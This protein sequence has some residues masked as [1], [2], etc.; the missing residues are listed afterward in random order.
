VIHASPD[1]P[2]V[3]VGTVASGVVTPVGD[4]TNLAFEEDSPAAGTALPVGNLPIG[5][6]ATGT[7]DPV[8]EFTVP[9]SA[10]L[11]AFAVAAG[12]L[13]PTN[14]QSFRLMVV[15]TNIFPWTTLEIL[16]N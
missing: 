5:V 2:A 11:Q 7:T 10:G 4:F 1:A 8:A 12:A 16:P 14:G 3:D 15:V 6:A 13:D 9:T